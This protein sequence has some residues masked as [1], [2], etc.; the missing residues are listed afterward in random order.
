MKSALISL[1]TEDRVQPFFDFSASVSLPSVCC[2]SDFCQSCVKLNNIEAFRLRL[3]EIYT[4]LQVDELHPH[5]SLID[6][7]N[8]ATAQ[9]YLFSIKVVLAEGLM[10]KDSQ[11]QPS[12]FVILSNERGERYGK[13]RTIYDDPDPKWDETFDVSSNRASW[14]MA[15]IKHRQSG[16]AHILL[17]RAYLRLDPAVYADAK[18]RDHL[19]PLD[20]QGH[21]LLRI[22]MEGERDETQYH[23]GRSFR[24]LKRTESD[25]IRTFV[26]KVKCEKIRGL[27][28]LQMTPV[29]RHTISSKTLKSLIKTRS[30]RLGALDYNSAL[31][32]VTSAYRSVD[33]NKALGNVSAAYKSALGSPDYSIP[34]VPGIAD[35]AGLALQ[36]VSTKTDPSVTLRGATLTDSDI[37]SAIHPLFDYLEVNMHTLTFN[38][39]HNAMQSVLAKLWKQVLAI[40]ESLIVPP[41]SGRRSYMKPLTGAELEVVLKWLVFLRSFFH[42]NGDP[43]GIPVNILNNEK[44]NELLR[45]VFYYDWSTDD[46]ME[47]SCDSGYLQ[48]S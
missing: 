17:G 14:F 43:N 45:I 13:T 41:L 37:E 7:E 11:R 16:G 18:P 24:W 47:V 6:E 35:Q 31:G 32:K 25:M 21:V 46:L 26:D 48:Q 1:Q 34:L 22:S 28:P 4:Q 15:S 5:G 27:T 12:T 38:L 40:I 19:L 3:D 20:T 2:S 42:L 33:Y 23:F 10:L 9:A 30:S 36:P 39:S 29:L 44:F 8:V